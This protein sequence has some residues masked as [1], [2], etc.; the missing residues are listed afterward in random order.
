VFDPE[1]L[2]LVAVTDSLRDGVDGLAERAAA[3]VRGGVTMLHLRLHD[4]SPRTLVEAARALRLAAPG[5]PL[6][7]SDRADVAI[8]ADADGVH[9]GSEEL[10][11]A[12]L[13]RVVPARFIIGVSVGSD[14]DVA[15]AAG[16][17]Y[18]G[19]GPVFAT[20]GTTGAGVAI[21]IARFRELAERCRLPS[22]AIGGISTE[23]VGA[24]LAAGASGIAVISALFGAVDP[25]RAARALRSA[26]DASER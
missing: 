6:L 2:R 9:V 14:D 17:D 21:G 19:I 1:V 4:E 10:S 13:R 26:Q 16:A 24:V 25:M 22:V 23:N 18:V 11:P 12:A 3:A 20:G 8:A 15:C 7:V 5:V